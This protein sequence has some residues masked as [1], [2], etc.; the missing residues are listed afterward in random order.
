MRS[1]RKPVPFEFVV[2]LRR[3]SWRDLRLTDAQRRAR[4]DDQRRHGDL[5]VDDITGTLCCVRAMRRRGREWR[6]EE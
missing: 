4:L 3:A 6:D 5:S 2:I 1:P